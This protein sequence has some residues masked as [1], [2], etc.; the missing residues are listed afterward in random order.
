[1]GASYRA[2]PSF[3][4]GRESKNVS[5][6]P[7]PR[8]A[9][10][11]NS[12][13]AVALRSLHIDDSIDVQA[14]AR[15]WRTAQDDVA[16]AVDGARVTAIAISDGDAQRIVGCVARGDSMARA[17][18]DLR[19][20]CS[21]YGRSVQA[22]RGVGGERRP[23]AMAVSRRARCSGVAPGRGSGVRHRKAREAHVGRQRMIQMP[24]AVQMRGDAVAIGAGDRS[25]EAVFREEMRFVCPYSDHGRVEVAG[26][27]AGRSGRFRGSVAGATR[28]AVE[29][30]F[31]GALR[32]TR[33][34]ARGRR[35][36]ESSP[37]HRE[38]HPGPAHEGRLTRGCTG[39]RRAS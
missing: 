1:M 37:T 29:T 28:V 9:E 12:T 30:R 14:R 36:D 19:R 8:A 34:R 21:P 38:H 39:G 4:Y 32:R 15:V 6:V 17:A 33:L 18:V 23:A 7:S 31:R 27:I 24:R 2:W 22:T 16:G 20:T 5:D 11:A 26:K 3:A 25:R 35:G 10:A 13:S